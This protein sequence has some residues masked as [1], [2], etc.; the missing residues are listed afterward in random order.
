MDYPGKRLP[1]LLL[2]AG[3]GVLALSAVAPHDYPTWVLEVLPI[4]VALPLLV[5]TGRSFPLT[6]LL[7]WLIFG[8][9]VLLM[10]GG[11]YTYARVPAGFWVQDWFG[12]TRNHYDRLGHFMQGFEPAILAREILLRKQ[13]VARGR[14]LVTFVISIT[15]AF[16]AFYE[17]IE[18]FVALVSAEA[19]DSFLGTQGDV[20]DTQWDMFMCLVGSITALVVL[21]RWHDGQL[22]RLGR[23]GDG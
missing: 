5:L 1:L 7:Y 12:F 9:A 23:R 10:V 16:S 21:P 15:L 6:P 11:H 18:W 13:V 22:A 4:F 19:A 3:F 14:W 17:L 8:H 20:W 2:G